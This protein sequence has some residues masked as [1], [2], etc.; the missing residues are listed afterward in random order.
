MT[1]WIGRS[2]GDH[3]VICHNTRKVYSCPEGA[4]AY[5]KTTTSDVINTCE[6]LTRTLWGTDFLLDWYAQYCSETPEHLRIQPSPRVFIEVEKPKTEF[7][8]LRNSY[9]KTKFL[10]HMAPWVFVAVTEF[11]NDNNLWGMVTPVAVISKIVETYVRKEIDGGEEYRSSPNSFVRH[12]K[13]HELSYKRILGMKLSMIWS[14]KAKGNVTAVSFNK[15]EGMTL[16]DF[17]LESTWDSVRLDTNGKESFPIIRMNDKLLFGSITKAAKIT[18]MDPRKIKYCCEGD[19][20]YADKW[21][22]KYVFHY[23]KWI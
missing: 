19:I 7:D 21:A 13:T 23:V 16:N 1:N 8:E 14:V 17:A 22:V 5:F 12:L 11:F 6:R 3:R 4:A 20:D 15:V 18:E 2:T 10:H 9:D